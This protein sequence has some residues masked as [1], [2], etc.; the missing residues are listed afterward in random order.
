LARFRF[1]LENVSPYSF[2]LIK[3]GSGRNNFT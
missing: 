2:L 1:G 3:E